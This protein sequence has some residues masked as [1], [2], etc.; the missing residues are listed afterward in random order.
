MGLA[1][2]TEDGD[3]TEKDDLDEEED[4]KRILVHLSSLSSACKRL[5]TCHGEQRVSHVRVITLPVSKTDTTTLPVFRGIESSRR[6]ASET[7]SRVARKICGRTR[8]CRAMWIT[9]AQ[10]CS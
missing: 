4:I 8:P 6:E 9:T 2:E 3:Q 7:W 5:V 1:D 10:L